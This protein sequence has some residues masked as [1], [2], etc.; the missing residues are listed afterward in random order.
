MCLFREVE[1]VF[2]LFMLLVVDTVH[3]ASSEVKVTRIQQCPTIATSASCNIR[4]VLVDVFA[5]RLSKQLLCKV[6]Q[7]P[8]W[9]CL[10]FFFLGTS[11]NTEVSVKSKFDL[12]C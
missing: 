7:E 3:L 1:P 4:T 5:L 11:W 10:E 9:E 8:R 2:Q 12:S 6:M